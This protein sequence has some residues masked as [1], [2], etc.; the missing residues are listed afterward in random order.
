MEKN[1]LFRG[2]ATALV[3]PFCKN[4]IDFAAYEKLLLTQREASALVVAGTTGEA[5][6]LSE[7][8]RDALLS[9]TLEKNGGRLPVIMGAGSYDTAHAVHF[10]KRAAA[11]GASGVLCVTPYYNKGTRMGVR[12]H[13][14]LLAE[15]SE[16][17]VILYNVPSRTGVNLSLADYEELLSHPNVAGVKEAEDSAEKFACL[18]KHFG[19]IKGIY[20]GNDA[21]LLPALSLGAD[22]VISVASNI[23]PKHICSV[24]ECFEKGDVE[25]A[26]RRFLSVHPIIRALFRETNPTPVKTALAMLGIGNGECRLPLTSAEPHTVEELRHLLSVFSEQTDG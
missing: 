15:A 19:A 9:F 26:R 13:F 21:F 14:L 22:G 1:I 24:F 23:I 5:P 16:I 25:S 2:V 4:G 17:P 8:E 6:T 3:T 7:R 10:V 12:Q 18:S 11:L 20:T